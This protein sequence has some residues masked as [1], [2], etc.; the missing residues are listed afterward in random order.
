MGWIILIPSAIIGLLT[1]I[2]EYEP[3][4]L[5]FKIPAIF[6]DEF[7]GEKN[8]VGVVNNN[9]LNEILGVLTILSSLFVAF[10]KKRQKMSIFQKS[11]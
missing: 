6:I 1:L 4:Y 5:D 3:S 10:L 8:F 7:F 2:Y 9:V 11:D